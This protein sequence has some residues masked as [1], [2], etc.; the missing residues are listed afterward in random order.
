MSIAKQ[1]LCPRCG[2]K[3]E[4]VIEALVSDGAR[5]VTYL[6]RCVC[7]W[8]KELE[9]LLIKRENGRVL[10]LRENVNNRMNNK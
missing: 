9:T 10:I 1:V 6:Y 8:R 7:R 5:R 4:F 3:A 2:R